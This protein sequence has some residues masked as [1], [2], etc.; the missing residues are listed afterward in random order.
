M[1]SSLFETLFCSKVR[2]R[3]L[4]LFVLNP[5]NEYTVAT[6]AE[7]VLV[8]RTDVSRELLRLK[9][10]GFLRE[11]SRRKVKAYRIHRDFPFLA[12]LQSL[13]TK[14]NA[15]VSHKMFR[16]L[17]SA[18]DVK[19]VLISGLFLNYPKAKADM[20]LVIDNVNRLRLKTAVE[21]LEAEVGR[22][23]RFVLMDPEEFQYRLNMLD[24][25][26][27]EFLGGPHQEIINRVPELKR[28][29]AGIRK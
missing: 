7:K 12:E 9:K 18:G 15:G 28:F 25:F 4:R 8:S 20:I 3:L 24:R 19:L 29:I 22:E 5:E 23:I 11:L 13:V 2:A 21:K 26:L 1:T 14:S 10:I 27:S 17:R 16:W 6:A